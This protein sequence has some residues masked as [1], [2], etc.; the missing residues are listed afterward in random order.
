MVRAFLSTVIKA[1]KTNFIVTDCS[2]PLNLKFSFEIKQVWPIVN[3]GR[4]IPLAHNFIDGAWMGNPPKEI[5]TG[6]TLE[7]KK[8]SQT[9]KK[10]ITWK[11]LTF[12]MC[13]AKTVSKQV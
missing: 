4:R 12:W 3:K 2:I 6:R 1:I 11:H 7:N 9:V 10:L 5:M 8:L 13:V